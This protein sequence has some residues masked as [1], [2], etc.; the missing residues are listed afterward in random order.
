M[1]QKGIGVAGKYTLFITAVKGVLGSVKSELGLCYCQSAIR[2][3]CG[4]K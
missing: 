1:G 4:K 2:D 3:E